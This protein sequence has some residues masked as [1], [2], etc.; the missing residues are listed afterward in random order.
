M[1]AI[2]VS[3]GATLGAHGSRDVQ[4]AAE[5]AEAPRTHRRSVRLRAVRRRHRRR[6]PARDPDARGFGGVRA[7]R[8]VRLARGSGAQAEEAPGFYG[9]LAAAI[10]VGLGLNFVGIDP[11]RALYVSAILNGLAAPP[12][13][14]LML[15]LSR[16]PARPSSER[17]AI[18][19]GSW[20]SP[21][22]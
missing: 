1:F 12:L 2:M 5:A 22:S 19:R 17:L 14:L 11:I 20:V 15:I 21:C 7:G 18:D 8:D 9:V 10:V 16:G 4:T 3:S 6:G 13:I